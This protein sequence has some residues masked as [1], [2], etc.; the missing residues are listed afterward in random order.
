MADEK[1]QVTG[2]QDVVVSGTPVGP[3]KT[4]LETKHDK[5]AE[6]SR[7]EAEKAQDQAEEK[8][9]ET[10]LKAAIEGLKAAQEPPEELPEVVTDPSVATYAMPGG[11]RDFD[12][13]PPLPFAEHPKAVRGYEVLDLTTAYN[14]AHSEAPVP[15]YFR[16][17]HPG[18]IDRHLDVVTDGPFYQYG[19]ES[20][21]TKASEAI[22]NTA[23]DRLEKERKEEK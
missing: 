2:K 3:G 9:P 15:G 19:R 14:N 4:D 6:K 12:L 18:D 10:T 22:I 13:T 21:L 8:Q 16:V 11:G 1:V 5:L 7:K 23:I 17:T 20:R